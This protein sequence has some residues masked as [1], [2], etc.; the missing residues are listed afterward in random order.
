MTRLNLEQLRTFLTVVRVGGV[1][2]AAD[3]LSLTQPAVT[4]RIR[5]LEST[6]GAELFE[7]HATGMRLTKRGELLLGYARQLEQLT[8]L[9]EQN[10]VAPEGIEAHLRIGVSETIAQCW[11][12]DLIT[13]LHNRFPMLQI[14]FNVDISLNLRQQL[15]DGEIDLG[16][17][18]GPVSEYSVDNLDLPDFELAWYAS[19]VDGDGAASRG[20]F[21]KPVITYARHTRPYREL[22]KLLLH[23][24]GPE[25]RLFPSSSLTLCF[26]LVEAGLGVAALPRRLGSEYVAKGRLVE[27]DPGW[28]PSPL[29]FT[30]SY[31]ADPPSHVVVASARIAQQVAEAFA[32]TRE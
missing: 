5:N 14:E 15:L 8:E 4:A 3:A 6:V 20:P 19:A 28:I 31:V 24:V 18:L 16:V 11:L 1:I 7:R 17:L 30:V 29:H 2:K 13:E 25:V 10:V 22:K 32:A 26:R 12:P 21:A 27:F 9:I 23:H